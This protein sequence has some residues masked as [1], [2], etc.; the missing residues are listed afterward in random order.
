MNCLNKSTLTNRCNSLI[1][2]EAILPRETK[3]LNKVETRNRKPLEEE[4]K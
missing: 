2:L 1:T 4:K 3:I